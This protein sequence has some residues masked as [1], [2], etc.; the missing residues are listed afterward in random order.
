MKLLWKSNKTS[1]DFSSIDLIPFISYKNYII[2]NCE[3]I[4]VYKEYLYK[5]NIV[6]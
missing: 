2:I 1:V 4:Q 6:Q 3:Y 5:C